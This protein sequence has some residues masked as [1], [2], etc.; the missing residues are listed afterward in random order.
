MDSM[1]RIFVQRAENEFRLAKVLITLS[2]NTKDKIELGA[3]EKDTFYS[4]AISHAYYAIFYAAKALLLTEGIK[5]AAPE[6]HRKT[7]ETFKSA[8][9]DTGKLD[10]ALLKTYRAAIVRA[11]ELLGL[12][13]REKWKRGHFTYQTIAQANI[14]FAIES[15]EGARKFL[16]SIFALIRSE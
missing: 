13:E 3:D 5:T 2:Q 8:F 10:V 14:P 6:I 7:F 1:V 12:F 15:A 9:V 16:S 4:A 11:D